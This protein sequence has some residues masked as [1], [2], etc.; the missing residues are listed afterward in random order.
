LQ[1]RSRRRR[2]LVAIAAVALACIGG[3]LVFA[4]FRPDAI[5]KEQSLPKRHV[6][7]VA[8]RHERPQYVVV[9]FDGSGGTQLWP[10]WRAVARKV[11]AHFTF[12]VSGVYLLDRAH[13]RMYHPPRHE[14]GRSDIGFAPTSEYARGTLDQIAAAYREGD[15]IGTCLGGTRFATTQARSDCSEPGRSV[16]VESGAYRYSRSRSWATPFA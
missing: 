12:F 13:A 6:A 15:E 2:R 8:P 1:R 7:S 16:S 14:P 10:Y 3:P 4:G 9:S 11:H 5:A